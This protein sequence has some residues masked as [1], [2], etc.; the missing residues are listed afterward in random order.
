MSQ[1]CDVAVRKVMHGWAA[2]VEGRVQRM[3]HDTSAPLCPSQ[4]LLGLVLGP[5]PGTTCGGSN[6][7]LLSWSRFR[8]GWQRRCE[9]WE[10]I[11]GSGCVSVWR[12]RQKGQP[13]SRA[14]RTALQREGG[15]LLGA[16]LRPV[17]WTARKERKH[18]LTA[19][20]AWH[21]ASLPCEAAEA[22][23]QSW[24]TICHRC[25]SYVTGTCIEQGLD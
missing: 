15:L 13:S 24:T 2:G 20:A 10:L 22:I 14:C 8:G 3:G 25:Y 23:Q 18:S 11:K 1:Q 12:R 21:W 19:R 17:G 16:Q 5:A 4:A 7:W 6:M 9:A